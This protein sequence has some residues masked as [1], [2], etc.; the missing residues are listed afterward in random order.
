MY[1]QC[2]CQHLLHPYRQLVCPEVYCAL[3]GRV[4]VGR[5]QERRGNM[6]LILGEV[7]TNA[8]GGKFLPLKGNPVWRSTEPAAIMWEPFG[9]QGR[10]RGQGQRLPGSLR[11]SGR[12]RGG[13]GG[14][15]RQAGARHVRQ[16]P[17][18]GQLQERFQS[19]LKTLAQGT[20]LPT[21]ASGTARASAPWRPT[22]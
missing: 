9:L 1:L 10:G 15:R 18:R 2:T 4:F 12:G 17:H 14:G 7:Q 5:H 16:A 6:E 20:T 11:R 22:V 8:R 21:C 13:L 19:C 3:L